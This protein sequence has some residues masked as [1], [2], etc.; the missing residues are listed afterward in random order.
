MSLPRMHR[1]DFLKHGM[2]VAGTAAFCSL[3]PIRE[4]L[5][6][7]SLVI[8]SFHGDPGELEA[9]LKTVTRRGCDF[10]DIFIEQV[11]SRTCRVAGDRVSAIDSNL[12]EGLAIRVDKGGRQFFEFTDGME[13]KAARRTAKKLL[14][15]IP[16]SGRQPASSINLPSRPAVDSGIIVSR[17]KLERSSPAHITDGLGKLSARLRMVSNLIDSVDI[18]YRDEIRRILVANSQGIYVSDYQPSVDLSLECSARGG[19]RRSVLRRRIAQRCGFE[20]L[21]NPSTEKAFMETVERTVEALSAKPVNASRLPVILMPEASAWL[22]WHLIRSIQNLHTGDSFRPSFPRMVTL[23]DSG[24]IVDAYG[25]AHFDDEG[26]RTKETVLIREGS[27]TKR[28]NRRIGAVPSV[29]LTGNGRR[30]G[31]KTAPVVH[32]TNLYFQPIEH[33]P[34]C[35]TDSIRTGILVESAVPADFAVRPDQVRL[36]VTSGYMIDG[37][38]TTHPVRNIELS[39]SLSDMLDRITACG[40]QPGFIPVALND[41]AIPSSCGAPA[42]AFSSLN[43]RQL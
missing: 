12:R 29:E 37:Y 19:A 7:S 17:L 14:E 27:V 8:D 41:P 6:S 40:G 42:L 36:L 38:R 18:D 15:A 43:I 33:L 3:F 25:S 21:S 34:D 35:A 10:A 26:C 22:S 9:L 13:R 16:R 2:K 1:R 23:V 20:M 30:S 5:A 11:A 32:P 28:L 39:G 24:R 4:I 31:Y